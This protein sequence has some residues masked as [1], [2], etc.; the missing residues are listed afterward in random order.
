MFWDFAPMEGSTDGLILSLES[1]NL[2]LQTGDVLM[3]FALDGSRNYWGPYVVGRT[4]LPKR[5]A[6]TEWSLELQL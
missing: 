6:S 4:S 5:Q 3:A 2:K 1:G